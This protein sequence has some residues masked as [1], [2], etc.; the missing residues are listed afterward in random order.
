MSIVDIIKQIFKPKPKPVPLTEDQLRWNQIWDIW[1]EGKAES[2]YAELM[3]YQGEVGN[4]GHSQFF[5]NL[6][7]TG[8]LQNAMAVLK[9]VLSDDLKQNLENAYEVHLRYEENYEDEEADRMM[10]ACD[11]FFFERESEIT[12]MLEQYASTLDQRQYKY[13]TTE[14]ERKQEQRGTL[15]HEFYKGKW[16]KKTFWKEDSLLLCDDIL[17]RT[18]LVKILE[19]LVCNYNYYGETEIDQV[20]WETILKRASAAG[21]ELEQVVLELE[22]WVNC[23]YEEHTVFTI[24]GI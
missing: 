24:L 10:D 6:S 13:L 4:G 3:A 19:E 14:Q 17:H 8:D 18:G 1:A 21:G 9:E 15:Y 11:T 2:P 5:G 22:P 20:Q 16:D 23:N 12:Q 7:A